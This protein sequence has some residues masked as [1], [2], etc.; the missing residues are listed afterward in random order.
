MG[1]FQLVV[2]ISK[3]ESNAMTGL[4]K[5]TEASMNLPSEKVNRAHRSVFCEDQLKLQ[6][7]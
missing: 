6:Y 1:L 2:I 5:H 3:Q 7:N 4:S